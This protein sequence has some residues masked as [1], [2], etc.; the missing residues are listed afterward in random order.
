MGCNYRGNAASADRNG[1]ILGSERKNPWNI[2]PI[3][4]PWLYIKGIVHKLSHFP[5]KG[6]EKYPRIFIY[7]LHLQ[8]FRR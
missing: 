4:S 6:Y 7:T 2:S 1:E 3:W 8:H 5:G